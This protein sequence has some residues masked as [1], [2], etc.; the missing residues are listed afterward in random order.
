M[1]QAFE[2]NFFE[3]TEY[4]AAQDSFADFT[5]VVTR[6]VFDPVVGFSDKDDEERIKPNGKRKYE[7]IKAVHFSLSF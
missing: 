1:N 2:E 3:H 5:A 7:N 6:K 4:F